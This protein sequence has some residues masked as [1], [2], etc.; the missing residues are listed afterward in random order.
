MMDMYGMNSCAL[1]QATQ[2]DL[3]RYPN[4]VYFIK[5]M[6]DGRELAVKKVVKK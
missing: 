2:I 1:Q 3:S 5:V 4:G 6:A